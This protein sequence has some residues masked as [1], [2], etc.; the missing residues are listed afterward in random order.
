[1]DS[2]TQQESTYKHQQFPPSSHSCQ[3]SPFALSE[4]GIG[5]DKQ[6]KPSLAPGILS[7]G[8]FS[9]LSFS[10]FSLISPFH[11]ISRGWPLCINCAPHIPGFAHTAFLNTHTLPF[12]CH[13]NPTSSQKFSLNTKPQA[14][15]YS[16]PRRHTVH[17]TSSTQASPQPRVFECQLFRA[18][19]NVPFSNMKGS[20]DSVNTSLST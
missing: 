19:P 9:F 11:C 15:F 17:H 3:R 8:S 4:W 5:S 20:S 2:S 10:F 14:T 1:M 16:K 13:L 12:F 7:P 6:E 18:R